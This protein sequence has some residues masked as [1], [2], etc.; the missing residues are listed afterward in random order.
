MK[1]LFNVA[2]LVLALGSTPVI[3]AD[4]A[5]IEARFKAADKNGDG[6]LTL[7]EAK[8]GMSRVAKAFDKIDTDKKGYI[9]LDQL[10]AKAAQ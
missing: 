7:E 10:K 9:T 4:M 8:A 2:A 5:D 3:A 1:S 6:K